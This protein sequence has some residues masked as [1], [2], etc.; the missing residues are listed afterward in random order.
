VRCTR[1]EDN[2]Y[3]ADTC[4]TGR[5]PYSRRS[6]ESGELIF[7]MEG[8]KRHSISQSVEGE[9]RFDNWLVIDKDL[10]LDPASPCLYA[11]HSCKLN[12]GIRDA[13][14]FIA[15]RNI[16]PNEQLT[17]DYS[18][19]IDKLAWMMTCSC[20]LRSCRGIIRSI[21]YL[22]E[23]IYRRYLPYVG[24]YVQNVYAATEAAGLPITVVHA[25]RA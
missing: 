9:F 23:D 12:L 1:A 16:G 10:F 20:G 17:Y 22:P 11:N 25:A 21:Q 24:R 4:R 2:L 5:G 15:S 18:L 13:L 8:E 6:F 14:D 3:I 19:T 7:A